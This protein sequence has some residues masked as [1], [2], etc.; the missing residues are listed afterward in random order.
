MLTREDLC[1]LQWAQSFSITT[2][3]VIL[4]QLPLHDTLFLGTDQAKIQIAGPY[5]LSNTLIG[6]FLLSFLA[7]KQLSIW[8][9]QK[10]IWSIIPTRSLVSV[11]SGRGPITDHLVVRLL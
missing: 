8:P 7:E 2:L 6:F 4:W 3:V 1:E 9:G 10:D 11:S 5:T